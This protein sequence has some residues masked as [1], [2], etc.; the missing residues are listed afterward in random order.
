MEKVAR[1]NLAPEPIHDWKN[2]FL[3]LDADA[4]QA[5]DLAAALKLWRQGCNDHA[6][7]A[8]S[9]YSMPDFRPWIG[10]VCVNRVQWNPF[11]ALTTLWGT[12]LVDLYGVD[13][14][15]TTLRR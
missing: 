10:M 11:D 15:G 1:H 13:R 14:T 8:W 4:S 3:R 6:L 5:G 7:P 9:S 12:T 2:R